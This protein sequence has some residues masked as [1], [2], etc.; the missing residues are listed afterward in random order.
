M[1]SLLLKIKIKEKIVKR[2]MY[3][4]ERHNDKKKGRGLFH[5]LVHYQ[6]PA[7]AG[8]GPS[9][10]QEPRAPSIPSMQRLDDCFH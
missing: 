4:I 9:Q 5:P 8:A 10:S 6:I 2:F 3:V 1:N 7:S